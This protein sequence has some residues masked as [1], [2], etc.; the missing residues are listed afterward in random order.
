MEVHLTSDLNEAWMGMVHWSLLTLDGEIE[1]SGLEWVNLEPLESRKVVSKVFD[2][3]SYGITAAR[4]MVFTAS[5]WQR[6]LP[7]SACLAPFVPNKHLELVDPGL[8]VEVSSKDGKAVF[9]LTSKS[10]ARFVELKV[11]GHEVIFSDNYFDVTPEFKVEVTC[12]L[13]D[14]LNLEGVKQNLKVTSL[15]NSFQ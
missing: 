4:N 5:L 1:E 7:V 9:A 3:D 12:D 13:P 2:L 14:G 11:E 10:L 15:Y 6:N 8:Q